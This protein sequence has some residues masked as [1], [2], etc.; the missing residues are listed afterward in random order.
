MVK[1]PGVQTKFVMLK[2]EPERTYQVADQA[3]QIPEVAEIYTLTGDFDLLLKCNLSDHRKLGEFVVNTLQALEGTK[4]T[5]TL[6]T[7][8]WFV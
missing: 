8:R 2:C 3:V 7:D 4:D 6:D 1:E 5:K